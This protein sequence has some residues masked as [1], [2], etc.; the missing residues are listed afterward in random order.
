MSEE[1]MTPERRAY[2]EKVVAELGFEVI[3]GEPFIPGCL[4]TARLIHPWL[5]ERRGRKPKVKENP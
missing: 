1:V 5:V 3:Q 4:E 2:V